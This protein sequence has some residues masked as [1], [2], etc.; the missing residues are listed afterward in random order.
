MTDSSP[1]VI[2]A[3]P[4]LTIAG[5]SRPDLNSAL[6]DM[7]CY[8]PLSGMAHAEIR[9]V[10]WRANSAD[11]DAGFAFQEIEFGQELAIIPGEEGSDPVFV[12]EITGIEE[13][14]GSGAPQ[15]V[16]LAEDKL[17]RLARQRY[18]RSFEEQSIEDVLSSIASEIGL[19]ANAQVGEAVGTW[20]QLNESNLA[21]LKRLLGPYDI[22]LRIQDGELRARPE[23]ADTSPPLLHPQNNLKKVRITADLNHQPLKAQV[24]GFDLSS[25]EETSSL[26]DSTPQAS[27]GLPAKDALGNLSWGSEEIFPHPFARSQVEAEAWAKAR[28]RHRAKRFLHGEVLCRGI[29][30]LRSG[31]EVELEGVSERL[32]G[33][34]QVVDC[35]HCFDS[36]DGYSTKLAVQR[37]VLS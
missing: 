30:D 36:S 24:R 13:R 37:G 28:F 14:Y 19:S 8:L 20:H 2:S 5:E 23:E 15:L 26:D 29:P 10:N 18:N 6:L 7:Q 21:F 17:Q 12:G 25:D 1:A 33:L 16:I 11:G 4:R 3:R 35:V 32:K 22:A 9:C 27:Q 34:Y 31:R